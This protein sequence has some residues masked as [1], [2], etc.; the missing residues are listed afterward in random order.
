MNIDAL[1]YLQKVPVTVVTMMVITVN[2]WPTLFITL[3]AKLLMEACV[4]ILI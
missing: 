2:Q 1:L 3:C 4:P